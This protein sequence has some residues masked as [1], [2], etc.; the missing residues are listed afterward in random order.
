[1]NNPIQRL[2]PE[3]EVAGEAMGLGGEAAGQRKER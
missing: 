2:A 3:Q 1:M